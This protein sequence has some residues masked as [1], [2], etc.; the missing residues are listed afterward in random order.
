MPFSRE[1]WQHDPPGPTQELQRDKRNKQTKNEAHWT[2]NR[3]ESGQRQH[4]KHHPDARVTQ[5]VD[6]LAKADV[7]Y[8]ALHTPG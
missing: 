4:E 2:R 3:N 6:N 1:V 7:V 5:P 8:T